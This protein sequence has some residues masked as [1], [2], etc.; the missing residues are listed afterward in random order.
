[1]DTI[2]PE[3][4]R[5]YFANRGCDY[6]RHGIPIRQRM[7]LAKRSVG[8]REAV[9]SISV[10]R[11]QVKLD[12][13]CL[14]SNQVHRLT[15]LKLD[16]TESADLISMP[17]PVSIETKRS[18]AFIAGLMFTLTVITHS[19]RKLNRREENRSTGTINLDGP[20]EPLE[21][22]AKSHR[23]EAA[24]ASYFLC[25]KDNYADAVSIAKTI[26]VIKSQRCRM[27]WI[28]CTVCHRDKLSL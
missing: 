21:R 3:V 16:K 11:G 25:P 12:L 28:F 2:L 27:R 23:R 8:C 22:K 7:I 9:G 15:R 5:M 1:V 26:K 18:A 20:W 6:R 14:C 10:E 24:G 17:F 13:P 19:R 4:V